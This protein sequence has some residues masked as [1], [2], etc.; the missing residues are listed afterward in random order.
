MTEYEPY[1]EDLHA[2][3][4]GGESMLRMENV[5]DRMEED[6]RIR[7]GVVSALGKVSLEGA[8]ELGLPEGIHRNKV[9]DQLFDYYESGDE[10]I[11]DDIVKQHNFEA[12][13]LSIYDSDEQ[14]EA[15]MAQFRSNI[16]EARESSSEAETVIQ[17]EIMAGTLLAEFM[18]A[19]FIDPRDVIVFIPGTGDANNNPKVDLAETSARLNERMEDQSKRYII[20]GYGGTQDGETVVLFRSGTDVIGAAV[21][22]ALGATTYE[23]FKEVEGVYSAD[24]KKVPNAQVIPI[25]TYDEARDYGNAG[26]EVLHRDVIGYLWD[27]NDPKLDRNTVTLVRSASKPDAPGTRIVGHRTPNQEELILGMTSRDD[28]V[29]IKLHEYG[30]NDRRGYGRDVLDFI[31]NYGLDGEFGSD[32]DRETYKE[33]GF[34]HMPSGTDSLTIVMRKNQFTQWGKDSKNREDLHCFDEFKDAL[35]AAFRDRIEHTSLIG[36]VHLVGMEQANHNKL[37]LIVHRLTGSFFEH[38][39]SLVGVEIPPFSTSGVYYTMTNSSA[40][41]R[42]AAHNAFYPAEGSMKAA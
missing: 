23:V 27:K 12:K 26:A 11:V 16:I 2:A 10:L 7:V 13:R 15:M 1:I 31:A 19:E 5:R 36:S 32:L 14:R 20:G 29:G 22:V 24:P 35:N 18:G 3:K 6:E 41:A 30:M 28:F 40:S 37:A 42:T 25:M 21:S 8:V 17:G 39:V 33:L 38:E 9:T 34:E 4:I